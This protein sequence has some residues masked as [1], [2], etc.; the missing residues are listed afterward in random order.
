MRA[1]LTL[2][3]LAFVSLIACSRAPARG[4]DRGTMASTG[5]GTPATPGGDAAAPVPAAR[6]IVHGSTGPSTV[7]VEVVKSPG[8]IQRGL[9]YR[10]FLAPDAGMLFLMPDEDDHYFWMKNTLIPLDIIFIKADATVAGVLEN[11]QPHDTRSK[12]VGVPSV[13]V[14]EV[15]AGWAKA[16]GVGPGTRITFEGVEAA[17]R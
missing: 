2:L 12:G 9:M 13:Y 15:N 3:T 4:D 10:K 17:A 7:A 16:H 1:G 11:M 8:M 14:L 5:S 6:V